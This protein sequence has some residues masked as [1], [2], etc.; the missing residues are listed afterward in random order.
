MV[1][2]DFAVGQRLVVTNLVRI[3]IATG[4]FGRRGR[5]Q[6]VGDIWDISQVLV[7]FVLQ[8]WKEI[9]SFM[10]ITVSCIKR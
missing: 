2:S 8:R 1:A 5:R 10:I 6:F 4:V 9:K 7:A 3:I